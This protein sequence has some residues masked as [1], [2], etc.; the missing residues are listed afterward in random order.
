M[1]DRSAE[2][3]EVLMQQIKVIPDYQR[4]FV[5]SANEL[6]GFFNDLLDAYNDTNAPSYFIGSMVFEK[7]ENTVPQQYQVVDG[8]QRVTSLFLLISLAV[9]VLEDRS[10]EVNKLAHVKSNCIVDENGS[11]KLRSNTDNNIA[12]AFENVVSSGTSNSNRNTSNLAIRAIWIAAE[13]LKELLN[14]NFLDTAQ[15]NANLWD[16]INFVRHKVSF[17]YYTSASPHESLIVF[18]RLNSSGKPLSELEIAK[19]SLFRKVESDDVKWNGLK[20]RWTTLMGLIGQAN[21]KTDKFFLRHF[22]AV[23]YKS[24]ILTALNSNGTTR[25]Y[26]GNGLL[27]TKDIMSFIKDSKAPLQAEPIK[28]VD[29]LI[30]FSTKLK[31]INEGKDIFGKHNVMIKNISEIS[32]SKTHNLILLQ[33]HDDIVFNAAAAVSL[34]QTTINKLLGK[35]VGGTEKRFEGWAKLIFENYQNNISSAEIARNLSRDALKEFQNDWKDVEPKLDQFEYSSGDRALLCLKMMEFVLDK[36]TGSNKLTDGLNSKQFSNITIDHIEPQNSANFETFGSNRLGNLALLNKSPNSA[37]QDKLYHETVKQTAY[38]QSN[39]YST[40]F[41]VPAATNYG[42]MEG[43]TYNDFQ[44]CTSWNDKEF[45]I[46]LKTIKDLVKEFAL[47]ELE[48]LS[49]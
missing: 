16:F 14:E 30:Q 40:K 28:T 43:T 42:G 19:G 48:S 27:G 4:D 29:A 13:I 20:A 33:A 44:H 23:E 10:Y 32:N 36:K 17:S 6:T 31:E 3:I 38:Q 5:W 46:R 15:D 26:K 8:Q 22:I 7:V 25:Q 9:R 21:I 34:A 37:I 45:G 41:L 18:E 2:K 39:F 11:P 49:K 24:F 1:Q 35:Y 47:A 12:N